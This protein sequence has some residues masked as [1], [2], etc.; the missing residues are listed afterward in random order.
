MR[1]HEKFSV[2]GKRWLDVE[3]SVSSGVSFSRLDGAG[4]LNDDDAAVRVQLRSEHLGLCVEMSPD[5]A[6]RLADEIRRVAA[7]ASGRAVLRREGRRAGG[8]S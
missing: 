8:D 2:R 5:E 3:H 1:A 4:P 7:A 6:L